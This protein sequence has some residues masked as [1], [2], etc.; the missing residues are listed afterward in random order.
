MN[1]T[2][3]PYR[4]I[5]SCLLLQVL[6][7]TMIFAQEPLQPGYIISVAGDSIPGFLDLRGKPSNAQKIRFRNSIKGVEKTYFPQDLLGYG[8]T[9]GIFFESHEVS[10]NRSSFKVPNLTNVPDPVI[11]EGHLFL[12]A[13]VKGLLSMYAFRDDGDNLHV[14]LQKGDQPPEPLINYRY[15]KKVSEGSSVVNRLKEKKKYL[16]QLASLMRDCEE[17]RKEFLLQKHKD[18]PWREADIQALVIRYNRLIGFAN[19]WFLTDV[20]EKSNPKV[21]VGFLFGPAFTQLN[22]V[23]GDHNRNAYRTADFSTEVSLPVGL[24]IHLQSKNNQGRWGFQGE[25]VRHNILA[26]S[27]VAY[28]VSESESYRY[29][30]DLALS[31]LR[32][33]TAVRYNLPTF[34]K[35]K[36]FGL[37]GLSTGL[38]LDESNSL[39]TD[40]NRL[41]IKKQTVES[42]FR[43]ERLL[44]YEL[45]TM[46]AVG[47]TRGHFMLEVKYNYAYRGFSPVI[48]VGTP[49]HSLSILLGVFL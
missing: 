35:F 1:S 29:Q 13:Y 44:D 21:Q 30:M 34:S 16:S 9:G 14:Y 38:L 40:S 47:V 11:E 22:F 4:K 5:F 15:L 39:I 8:R 18:L 36:P 33:G 3:L 12:Q 24:F 32:I 31:Y 46:A 6:I 25:L 41:G 49:N 26:K 10:I 37:L 7:S 48:G 17:L 27:D 42:V 43:A 19:P 23:T 20:A 28:S 45:G 2:F